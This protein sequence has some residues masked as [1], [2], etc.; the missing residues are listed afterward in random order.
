MKFLEFATL[1]VEGAT[2]TVRVNPLIPVQRGAHEGYIKRLDALKPK[3]GPITEILS[4][5]MKETVVLRPRSVGYVAYET[6]M[7][8]AFSDIRNGADAATVLKEAQDQLT[9][10][11]ARIR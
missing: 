3:I 11:F 9:A 7:Q 10:A 2:E 6:A 8:R 5:E 4:H 1:T